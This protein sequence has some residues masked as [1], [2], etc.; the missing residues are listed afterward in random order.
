MSDYLLD[1]IADAE[2][3]TDPFPHL[4][5]EHFLPPGLWA[6][7]ISSS[8]VRLR[9]A[10]SVDQLFTH[11]EQVGFEPIQ[12]PG[13]TKNRREYIKWL[14]GG[15]TAR[16]THSTCEAKG[17]ALRCATPQSEAIKEVNEFFT[18]PELKTL[19]VEKFGI[20]KPVRIDGGLQKYL[21]GYEISPHPDIRKKALTWMLNVNP[22]PNSESEG[23][24][25]HYMRFAPEWA[26]VQDYW[27]DNPEVETCWVPWGWCETVTRQTRNN[28][29]VIFS[30]RHDTLHAVKAHYNHLTAQRTQF[31]GNLWY[32][33]DETTRRPEHQD[34]AN[35]TYR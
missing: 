30:P 13:C 34:F 8:E 4:F 2:F 11:L 6:D 32:L 33:K 26:W 16:N 3:R 23:Y 19:L 17:M 7:V 27:R 28:S 18:S 24:H 29:L 22:G 10:K 31:Y 25:T 14:Q 35:G 5:I 21:H 12:F 9:E 20:T 15:S 1:K